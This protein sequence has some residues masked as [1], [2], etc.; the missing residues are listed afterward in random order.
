MLFGL[1]IGGMIGYIVGVVVMC[2][3]SVSRG[4]DMIVTELCE[5]LEEWVEIN[6][7]C[8]TL[9]LNDRGRDLYDRSCKA[10]NRARGLTW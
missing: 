8:W 1:I 4:T 10:L 2:L 9:P 6:E 7:H 5:S 3:A